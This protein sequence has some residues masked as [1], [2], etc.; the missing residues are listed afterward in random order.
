MG[1]GKL[2]I[3]SSTLAEIYIRQGY[4]DKA[5]DV[6]EKLLAKDA[7]NT[8]YKSRLLL[9]SPDMPDAKRLK[10]LSRLLKRIEEKRDEREA[11]K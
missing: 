10:L 5:R 7:G 11:G 1:E 2:R 6:Y 8:A 3:L 4:F 9:L